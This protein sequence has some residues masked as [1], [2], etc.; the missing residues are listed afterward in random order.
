MLDLEKREAAWDAFADQSIEFTASNC[1][2]GGYEAGLKDGFDAGVEFAN[3]WIPIRSHDELPKSNDGRVRFLGMFKIGTYLDY[4][5]FQN[6]LGDLYDSDGAPIDYCVKIVAWMPIP[7]YQ[8][9][10]DQTN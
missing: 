2:N 7:E 1:F 4:D 3:R 8:E 6:L 10:N 9:N 5:L